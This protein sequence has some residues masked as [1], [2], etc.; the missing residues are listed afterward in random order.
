MKKIN[1]YK[2][3]DR[4]IVSFMNSSHVQEALITEFSPDLNYVNLNGN[5]EICSSVSVKAE[6]D[7]SKSSALEYLTEKKNDPCCNGKCDC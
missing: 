1:E 3:G 5:W 7:S 6:L 4:L 2:I